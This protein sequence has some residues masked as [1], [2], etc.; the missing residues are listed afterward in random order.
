MADANKGREREEEPEA[1]EAAPEPVKSGT[2][3]RIV[4]AVGIFLLSLA[5]VVAGGF[6]NAKLYNHPVEYKLD[7]DG[8]IKP[9]IPVVKAQPA[10][11]VVEEKPAA[12][13]P[14][15]AIYLKMDPQMVVN[16]DANSEVKFLAVDMEFMAREQEVIDGL[17]RNMPKIRNNILMLISNRDYK[18]LMTREGKDQ[19]RAEALAEARKVLKQETGSG[20]KLEDLFFTSFVVQ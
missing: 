12:K 11:K 7:K 2:S 5:A 19:L 4:N 13:P 14:A 20:D 17:A 8:S 6:V 3:G 15:P 10:K 16:F 18:S 1:A 9:V